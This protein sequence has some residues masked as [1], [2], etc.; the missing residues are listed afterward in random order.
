MLII[1][2]IVLVVVM[3]IAGTVSAS[4]AVAVGGIS[5]G[6]CDVLRGHGGRD[7]NR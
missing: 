6:F 2:V 7:R 3:P 4:I 1:L 5:S